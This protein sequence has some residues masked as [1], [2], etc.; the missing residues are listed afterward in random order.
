MTSNNRDAPL[1]R[2]GKMEDDEEDLSVLRR[3]F[4]PGF[5]NLLNV[6][7]G[8]F[9]KVPSQK[10]MKRLDKLEDFSEDRH[11]GTKYGTHFLEDEYETTREEV[12]FTKVISD[13]VK[14]MVKKATAIET[15]SPLELTHDR[16]RS[17]KN[18]KKNGRSRSSLDETFSNSESSS[19]NDSSLGTEKS[20]SSVRSRSK[21]RLPSWITKSPKRKVEFSSAGNKNLTKKTGRAIKSNNE[22]SSVCSEK[23]SSR[24]KSPANNPVRKDVNST[25]THTK[26]KK[27]KKGTS[28]ASPGRSGSKTLL[29]RHNKTRREK[30]HLASS[31]AKSE[32]ENF[33][34]S[35]D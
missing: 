33:H 13:D 29:Q 22:E 2:E 35:L 27:E 12:F 24:R 32:K 14:E 15:K 5:G 4:S 7:S 3:I 20:E 21:V 30:D 17:D 1:R 9:S 11:Y 19:E 18:N 6:I 25:S 28:W 10:M 31:G 23:V 8:D 16:Y 34:L 26:E